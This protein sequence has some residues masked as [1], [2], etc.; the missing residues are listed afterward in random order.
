MY[1][2]TYIQKTPVI[3][4]YQWLLS[5]DTLRPI[6]MTMSS[7]CH[8]RTPRSLGRLSSLASVANRSHPLFSG[9]PTV[10]SLRPVASAARCGSLLGRAGGWMAESHKQFAKVIPFKEVWKPLR[11][12]FY[13]KMFL[14]QITLCVHSAYRD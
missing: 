2:E 10:P 14:L 9:F 6:P 4:F 13:V 7:C 5:V 11:F 3:G 1:I 12:F 8:C